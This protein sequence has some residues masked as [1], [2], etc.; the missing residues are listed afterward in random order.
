MRRIAGVLAAAGLLAGMFATAPAAHATG[1]ANEFVYLT[2]FKIEAQ[3]SKKSYEPRDTVKFH[4][5]V[6]R[7]AEEDPGGNGIPTPRP[8]SQPAADVGVNIV[9]FAD[10]VILID[11]RL[12]DENGKTTLTLKLPKYTPA[13]PVAGRIYAQKLVADGGCVVVFEKGEM[14]LPEAF[15]VRR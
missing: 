15:Q 1:C 6:T 13:G 2:T 4:I 11:Y 5:T 7:P 8:T 10:D 3:Q 14:L 9:L 12:T